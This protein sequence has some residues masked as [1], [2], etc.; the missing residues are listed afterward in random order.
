MN[1]NDVFDALPKISY[2]K[3]LSLK[4]YEYASGFEPVTISHSIIKNWCWTPVILKEGKRLNSNFEYAGW[5]ALDFDN[6]EYTLDE[7]MKD[8]CD[9]V[10]IIGTTK[11]HGERKN[12][13]IADRFRIV[14]L[15]D[16]IIT[17]SNDY[18]FNL[19]KLINK[20]GADPACSDPARFF[21]PCKDIIQITTDGFKQPV[22]TTN[23]SKFTQEEIDEKYEAYKAQGII[24]DW[25][26]GLLRY[27][28]PIGER[29]KSCFRLGL[30]LTKLGYEENEIIAM[31]KASQI[32]KRNFSE[33]E[34][35]RAVSNG[36]KTA[37]KQPINKE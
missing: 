7:A 35:R 13:I 11:S 21:Y 1:C 29:N 16:R 24:P 14:F 32:D 12:G 9:T 6:G 8:W 15:W 17:H 3:N 19:K 30:Y 5:G 4:P 36:V 26:K 27:G 23:K 10:S 22:E 34:L 28:G 25:I 37:L 31:I 33:E 20:Y 18:R 2:S